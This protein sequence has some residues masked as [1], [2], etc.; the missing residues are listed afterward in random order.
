VLKEAHTFFIKKKKNKQMMDY[1]KK[2]LRV[3]LLKPAIFRLKLTKTQS[4]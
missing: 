2:I 3:G 1:L 4:Y